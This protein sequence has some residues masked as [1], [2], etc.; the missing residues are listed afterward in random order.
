MSGKC[1]N[2]GGGGGGERE[3]QIKFKELGL[4]FLGEP[5]LDFSGGS[6]S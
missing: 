3:V 6:T 4:D 2:C 5:N 1:C